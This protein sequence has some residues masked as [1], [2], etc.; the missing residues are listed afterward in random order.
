M[1]EYTPQQ[2]EDI[3]QLVL[4]TVGRRQYIGARYVV[5][6][7]RKGESTMEW[8]SD[9]PYEPLTVVINEGNSYVSRQFVPTGVQIDNTEYW[10]PTFQFNAQIEQYRQQ[11]LAFDGRVSDLEE[12]LPVADFSDSTVSDKLEE[13]ETAINE[14]VDAD[15][16]NKPITISLVD[17][18][19]IDS[20]VYYPQGCT[21][22]SYG[23]YYIVA[24]RL[25][26]HGNG[27]IYKFDSELNLVGDPL[28]INTH[29]NTLEYDA[30]TH[31]LMYYNANSSFGFVDCNTMEI[32]HQTPTVSSPKFNYSGIGLNEKY[33]VMNITSTYDYVLF[34]RFGNTLNAFGVLSTP[35][36]G[37]YNNRQDACMFNNAF[38]QLY[39]GSGVKTKVRCISV[40]GTHAA[41]YVIKNYS[42][43]L[44][45][46]FHKEDGF[47]AVG[48]VFDD[49]GVMTSRFG[50]YKFDQNMPY[51]GVV[52]Q[53]FLNP[54]VKMVRCSPLVAGS[55]N[56]TSK[57]VEVTVG[58][59]KYNIG[60]LQY[61]DRVNGHPLS[62]LPLAINLL[63]AQRVICNTGNT[64]AFVARGVTRTGNIVEVTYYAYTNNYTVRLNAI[65]YN[66]NGT[67]Y[68]CYISAA[69]VLDLETLTDKIQTFLQT[70]ATNGLELG[71]I[72]IIGYGEFNSNT[73]NL[74]T[75]YMGT[76]E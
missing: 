7:G 58:T 14:I 67:E 76:S 52:S 13:L 30:T 27:I 8:D 70:A 12:A 56:D 42:G 40:G 31:R 60:V 29:G 46:I 22:D 32:V 25:A 38:Y 44:E 19:Q 61:L 18:F 11:L 43:E 34:H 47:Y 53:E 50:L 1:A 5:M 64:G 66:V 3:L 51:T 21:V 45:G 74:S 33:A 41:D 63:G 62:R 35:S 71:D 68:N 69:E 59:S 65:R 57:I 37:P 16:V 36:N 6:F 20:S 17:T 26:A 2:I 24:D 73:P 15:A 23:N 9:A 10:L 72:T 4:T 75:V 39:S 49:E 28:P 48:P 55:N 54:A